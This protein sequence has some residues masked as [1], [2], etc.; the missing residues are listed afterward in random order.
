MDASGEEKVFTAIATAANKYKSLARPRANRDPLRKVIFIVVT[1]ERGDDG[2]LLETSIRSCRNLGIP[3]FVIG[4]PAPFGREHTLVKYV[5]PDPKFDQT[6]QFAEVDQGPETYYPEHVQV[7]FTGDFQ[8]EPVIDSG[9]GPYALTRLCYETGGIYFTV[10]PNRNVR[11]KVRRGELD[12]FASELE[13][14]FDPT[15][16]QKYRPDYLA[17]RDYEAQVKRS[18]LRQSLKNA[19]QMKPVTG[20]SRP[21]T[22]F[23]RREDAQLVGDLSRAQQ[24]AA[25]LEP[26]LKMISEMLGRGFKYRDKETS[27]RWR[28]GYD[29][30]MGRVLAQKVRTETYN[31]ILAEAK[32]KAFKDPKNNTWVLK[33]SEEITVGSRWQNEAATAKKLLESVAKEHAGTPWAL[34]AS[35]ELRAPIGWMWTETYTDLTPR[36]SSPG[37]GNNNNPTPPKDDE[38]RMLKKKNKRPVPKL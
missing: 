15:I 23:V 8:R 35:E 27:P 7:G 26:K 12:A 21:R 28:A 36:P 30:A 13:Y 11:R 16:M 18:P 33:P 3:V 20:L 17:P 6:P 14:F 22:R 31:A 38:A 2:H 25:Q 4:V 9:F 37:N 1:D 34:L 29:L 10:H 32:S 5:D 19:A 24:D